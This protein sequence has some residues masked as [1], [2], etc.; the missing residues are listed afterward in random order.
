MDI[1]FMFA[2][3]EFF[4]WNLACYFR[5]EFKAVLIGP[6]EFYAFKLA[7]PWKNFYAK[8]LKN[9]TEFS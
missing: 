6:T 3:V 5:S 8:A 7:I 9:A 1:F 2:S 4:I